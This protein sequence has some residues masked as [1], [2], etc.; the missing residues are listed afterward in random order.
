M[1]RALL[2]ARRDFLQPPHGG[3]ILMI[4]DQP[5]CAVHPDQPLLGGVAQ[6]HGVSF[7]EGQELHNQ[8]SPL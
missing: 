3:Q 2:V 7:E 4:V 1:G 5:S 6:I 8:H